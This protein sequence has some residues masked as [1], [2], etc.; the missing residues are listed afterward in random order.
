MSELIAQT[1]EG[2]AYN[3]QG[4]WELIALRLN[5]PVILGALMFPTEESPEAYFTFMIKVPHKRIVGGGFVDAIANYYI[6]DELSAKVS[7]GFEVSLKAFLR[8]YYIARCLIEPG[9][10]G[11]ARQFRRSTGIKFEEI[12]QAEAA[13]DN[14]DLTINDWGTK[15]NED[16][17]PVFSARENCKRFIEDYAAAKRAVRNLLIYFGNLEGRKIRKPRKI[18]LGTGYGG[19]K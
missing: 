1:D 19:S 11:M 13:Q 5:K 6:L 2:L 9:N 10:D 15:K 8:K 3:N 4:K 18:D 12:D 16:G 17:K 7:D 14:I